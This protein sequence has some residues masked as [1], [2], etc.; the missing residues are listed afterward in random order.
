[1]QELNDSFNSVFR[2]DQ[3]SPSKRRRIDA[4]I[5]PPADTAFAG[6]GG[7]IVDEADA[8]PGGFV[9]DEGSIV[10]GSSTAAVEEPSGPIDSDHDVIPLREIPRLLDV[11]NLPSDAEVLAAFETGAQSDEEDSQSDRNA[12]SYSMLRSEMVS[13]INFLRVCAILLGNRSD[14]SDSASEAPLEDQEDYSGSE[15]SFAP[16]QQEK[17]QDQEDFRRATRA[18]RRR[19]GQGADTQ[20]QMLGDDVSEDESGIHHVSSS[21]APSS[22]SRRSKGKG[23]AS[24]S[25]G[26]LSG[27]QKQKAVDLFSAFLP[28]AARPEERS[29]EVFSQ[30]SLGLDEIRHVATL[31]RISLTDAEVCTCFRFVFPFPFQAETMG[32]SRKC[33][34]WLR[35]E[36][37]TVFRWQTLFAYCSRSMRF[38]VMNQ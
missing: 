33:S 22:K 7:F 31:V 9:I 16:S 2:K 38:R 35:R 13:R 8:A 26:E 34:R 1:M 4:R 20:L 30:K 17:D 10:P 6:P 28:E 5:N 11:M 24:R 27:S 19:R 29:W 12:T 37:E 25:E 18:S 32:R 14:D 3:P 15:V 36:A 23:K 21:A